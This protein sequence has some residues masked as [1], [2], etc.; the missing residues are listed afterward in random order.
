MVDQSHPVFLNFFP[1][2]RDYHEGPLTSK[3][4]LR[5]FSFFT[6]SV[7]SP[8]C[9]SLGSSTHIAMNTVKQSYVVLIQP[10]FKK[11]SYMLLNSFYILLSASGEIHISNILIKNLTR[12]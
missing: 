2:V 7:Y 10:F 3:H 6:Q 8:G 1:F 4:F 5:L 12:H 11:C 9:R